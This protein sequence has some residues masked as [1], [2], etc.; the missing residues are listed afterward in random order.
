MQKS[1]Y[2]PDFLEAQQ[3]MTDCWLLV[4][5]LIRQS[6]ERS[7]IDRGD[8]AIRCGKCAPGGSG[9]LRSDHAATRAANQ[10]LTVDLTTTW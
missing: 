10:E 5:D 1:F 3:R 9:M 7:A 8:P 4:K 6:L 2:K